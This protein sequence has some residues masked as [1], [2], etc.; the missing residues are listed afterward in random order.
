MP[1]ESVI[2]VLVDHINRNY[3][4]NEGVHDWQKLPE[5]PTAGE[6]LGPTERSQN[7]WFSDNDC[8]DDLKDN[9]SPASPD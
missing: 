4:R 9:P 6:I 2:N 7:K 3:E 8:K 1:T 5:I